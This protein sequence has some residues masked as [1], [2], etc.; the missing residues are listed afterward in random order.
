MQ[1]VAGVVIIFYPDTTALLS[2]IGSYLNFTEVLYVI[3]NTDD[4]Q[5][6]KTNEE[7]LAN[8]GNN[9]FYISN[10]GN[11]G[12][13]L[14][15]NKAAYLARQ[16]GYKW[17]L[18]MDH[19]SWF[20]G[21]ELSRY[22]Y[23]FQKTF[24]NDPSVAVVAPN[25]H[26]NPQESKKE[27]FEYVTAVI[28][29]GSLVHLDAWEA[30]KGFN[31]FLFI[32]EVDHDFCYRVIINGYKVAKFKNIWIEHTIGNQEKAGYFGVIARKK[33]VIHSPFRLYFM[34]RNYLYVRK[35]YAKLYPAEFERRNKEIFDTVKNNLLFGGSF[36]KNLKSIFKGFA[37]YRSNKFN[38]DL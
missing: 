22:G 33:R 32:D 38:T 34:V 3:D 2:H 21:D 6:Q 17:L 8:L 25:Y 9:I 5:L 37:D 15:L 10:N 36:L 23:E 13:G 11:K 7:K 28:T 16:K 27:E 26:K 4:F 18:T 1:K 19:D 35:K 29:S 12:I 31:E 20:S 14:S 24:F 30:V